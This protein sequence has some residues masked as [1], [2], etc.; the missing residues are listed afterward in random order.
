MTRQ[1]TDRALALGR[2]LAD[3]ERPIPFV[4]DS[5]M[6]ALSVSNLHA[7][8]VELLLAHR[9]RRDRPLVCDCGSKLVFWINALRSARG[10]IRSYALPS[11]GALFHCLLPTGERVR[12]RR[13]PRHPW[14]I[15]GGPDH[16]GNAGHRNHN[17]QPE[18]SW[19]HG[20]YS[21]YFR[22]S[23]SFAT[24]ATSSLPSLAYFSSIAACFC[25]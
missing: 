9:C 12:Q 11:S 6:V 3:D 7:A 14:G 2:P 5:K 24:A 17:R 15:S 23:N 25:G 10:G 4:V 22:S 19:T 13:P 1:A 20:G 21:G 16:G 18:G 8:E